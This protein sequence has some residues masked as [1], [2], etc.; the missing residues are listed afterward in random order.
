M[1]YL[2]QYSFH[3]RIV[4]SHTSLLGVF[5]G[6]G[7]TPAAPAEHNVHP[8]ALDEETQA[9]WESRAPAVISYMYH[10]CLMGQLPAQRMLSEEVS[11]EERPYMDA[12]LHR[13]R[14]DIAAELNSRT[15]D[16]TLH[17]LTNSISIDAGPQYCPT[18]PTHHFVI[19]NYTCN[20]PTSLDAVHPLTKPVVS[21]TKKA[22]NF[23]HGDGTFSSIKTGLGY[24]SRVEETFLM[25]PN[26]KK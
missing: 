11:N 20:P 1:F 16:A 22:H 23:S 9:L 7:N 8:A 15:E 12:L 19:Q 4:L 24:G 18:D 10:Q 5:K 13:V 25:N 3:K 6:M 26:S 14:K 2:P 17:T 21:F